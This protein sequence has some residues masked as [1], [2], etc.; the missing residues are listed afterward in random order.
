MTILEK[1]IVLVD[2]DCIKKSDAIILLEGD[3][4]NRCQ[5]AID[6]YTIG[7]ADTIV[8]SGGI[9]NP[10]YGSIPFPEIL[11]VLVKAGIPSEAV[12]HESVSQNTRDQAI[13]IIRLAKKSR[14]KKLILIGSH[15]H[16]YRAFL[17]FLHE[18]LNSGGDIILYNA[19]A[20]NLAWFNE[21]GW[22][23]RFD[24]LENEFV[25]IEKYSELGHLASY[26]EAIEYQRWKEQQV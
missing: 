20:N 3:G 10:E 11:P 19:P 8:F 1:F 17:T 7:F 12:Y 25:R 23:K 5:K 18:I 16:Q 21:T 6:L 15:Y 13:E 4:F 26:S 9:I 14:W 2:N 22:G 24:L